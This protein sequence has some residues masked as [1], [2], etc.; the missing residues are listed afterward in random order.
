MPPS[1]QP[2]SA[3]DA[4]PMRDAYRNYR[5]PTHTV[6]YLIASALFD[7]AESLRCIERAMP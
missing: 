7:I 6:E 2:A 4:D 1:G 3:R 5:G